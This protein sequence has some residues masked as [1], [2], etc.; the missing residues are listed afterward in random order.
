M[1]MRVQT[2]TDDN[3]ELVERYWQLLADNDLEGAATMQH[4]EFVEEWPQS[5][6]RIR[7]RDKWLAMAT[8]HP[9]FPSIEPRLTEGIEDLWVT[10]ARFEYPI[11]EGVVPFEVCAVQRVREGKVLRITQYFGAPFEPAEWREAWV[12]RTR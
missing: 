12:E 3:R 5:G 4:D 6:E 11:D 8:A 9:T 10:R 7:G 1:V 2:E